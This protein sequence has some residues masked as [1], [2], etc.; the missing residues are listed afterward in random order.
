MLEVPRLRVE[1]RKQDF[2]GKSYE[3]FI[4][5]MDEMAVSIGEQMVSHGLRPSRELTE[6]MRA[7]AEHNGEPMSFSPSRSRS[8]DRNIQSVDTQDRPHF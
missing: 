3:E 6:L 2:K 5:I 7:S 1:L 4:T 8:I